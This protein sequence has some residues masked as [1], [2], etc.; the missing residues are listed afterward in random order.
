MIVSPPV[1]TGSRSHSKCPAFVDVMLRYYVNRQAKKNSRTKRCTRVAAM[2]ESSVVYHEAGHAV[3]AVWLGAEVLHVTIQPDRDDGPRRDGDAMVRWHHQ[4]LSSRE[5]CERELMVVLAGPIAEMIHAEQRS[6]LSS[7][8]EWAGDWRIACQL[9]GTIIK[10]PTRRRAMID[11]II[12]K[13]FALVSRDDFWQAISEVA[14]LLDAHQTIESDE[15]A[16][17]VARWLGK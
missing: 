1:W 8:P 3:M 17:C 2:T 6:N 11:A 12:E 9:A 5:L 14:D 10:E 16:R 4:G 13:L 7:T 15:V